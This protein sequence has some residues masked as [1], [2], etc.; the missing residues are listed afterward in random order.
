MK[1]PALCACVLAVSLL[2]GCG[3]A[4]PEPTALSTPAPPA[5]ETPSPTPTPTPA[6]TPDPIYRADAEQLV[7]LVEEVHPCFPLED[8]PEGYE[9]AKA[10]FLEAASAAAGLEDFRW[11]AME[12]LT[13]LGDGHT[14]IR[15]LSDTPCLDLSWAADGERLYLLDGD[16]ALTGQEVT[17]IC[18]LSVAEVFAGIDRCLPAENQAGRDRNHSRYAGGRDLLLHLGGELH[19]DGGTVAVDGVE[20]MVPFSPRNPQ[21]PPP[22][23]TF[24]S[25]ERMGDV[26]YVDFNEC[27]P[28]D[29]LDAVTAQ[30]E[31]AVAEGVCK[32]IIDVRDNGGGDSSTCEALLEAM[33]MR[34]P[35]YGG[36]VRFS[37]LA[38]TQRGY[39]RD[40]GYVQ[41][42][43]NPGAARANPAI[44]LAVLTNENTFSSATMLAVFV[45]DGGL[46]AII[47]RPSA[48]APNSYGDTLSFELEH[49]GLSGTIS[50]KRWLRPDQGAERDAVTPDLTTAVGE[51]ALRRALAWLQEN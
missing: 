44:A 33:G 16:G 22:F 31:Q 47:G 4:A 2:A 28:G 36:C 45:R 21:T 27:R 20:Q 7:A 1:H 38:D 5:V 13:V 25:C 24:V 41:A 26:F 19:G 3:P 35:G 32:V 50:H 37:P 51:D 42:D 29:A 14:R 49:T 43:P 40:S 34:P 11:Q 30:L 18:G 15:S 23:D 6:P 10:R 9:A 46:G 12:Y 48:N 17:E 39:G 8:V